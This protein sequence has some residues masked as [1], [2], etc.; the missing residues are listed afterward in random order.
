MKSEF[1]RSLVE[2]SRAATSPDVAEM[3]GATL[4]Y[5]LDELRDLR[6]RAHSRLQSMAF[7]RATSD[8]WMLI[9]RDGCLLDGN[10]GLEVRAGKPLAE[11]RGKSAWLLAPAQ[12]RDWHQAVIESVLSVGRPVAYEMVSAW[13]RAEVLVQPVGVEFGAQM[14]LVLMR[15]WETGPLSPEQALVPEGHRLIE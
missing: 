5:C 9:A 12:R 15:F 6:Q 3:A 7:W 10:H 13:G 2:M 1:Y 8:V 14:A 11:L 4:A